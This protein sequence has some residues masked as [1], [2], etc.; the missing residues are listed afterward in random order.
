VRFVVECAPD[1]P[2]IYADPNKLPWVITNLCGNAL[3]YTPRGGTITVRARGDGPAVLVEVI[4][5]G[6]GIPREAQPRIFE[7]FT[8]RW[9]AEGVGRAGLGLYIAREIVEAHGGTIGVESEPGRGSRF[10]FRLPAPRVE[11]AP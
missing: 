7:K 5:T 2:P 10:F 11:G 8:Q 6:P 4:D 1:L 3:R 9:S